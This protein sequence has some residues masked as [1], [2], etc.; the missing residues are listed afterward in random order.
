MKLSK[1]ERDEK[2]LSLRINST[3]LVESYF[4]IFKFTS[5]S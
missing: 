5:K 1:R 4:Q 2:T 3:K